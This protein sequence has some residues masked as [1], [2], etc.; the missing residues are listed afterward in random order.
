MLI[1]RERELATLSDLLEAA[2]E[3]RPKL[4]LCGGEPGIG[5]TRLAAEVSTLAEARG[6]P[7][8]WARAPEDTAPPPFWLWRQVLGSDGGLAGA[9]AST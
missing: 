3:R 2:I 1:G 8:V 5:K 7:T 4:V 9:P 6:V